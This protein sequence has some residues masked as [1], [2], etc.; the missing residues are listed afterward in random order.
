MNLPGTLLLT[1]ACLLTAG[2]DEPTDKD[3]IQGTWKITS[4]TRDGKEIP[5]DANKDVRMVFSGDKLLIKEGDATKEASYRLDRTRK[6]AG[7]EIVPADGPHK[8]QK[9]QGIF[10]LEGDALKI[11]I[12]LA[13]GKTPPTEF[14]AKP[15][16]GCDLLVLHREKP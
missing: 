4:E 16:S 3:K 11:C 1:A 5:A 13:P 6:P 14:A 15:Q 10:A 7:I 8:G 9:L 2:A 12:L